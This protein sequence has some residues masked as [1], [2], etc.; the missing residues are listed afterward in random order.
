[1]DI[2][3]RQAGPKDAARIS[4]IYLQSRKLYLPYAPLA[5]SDDAVRA[6]IRETLIPSEPVFVAETEN[7]ILG[8]ISLS[9]EDSVR[10]IDNLYLSPDSTGLGIGKLL[11]NFAL[12]KLEPPVRLYA[13]QEN[14]GARKF[15][16]AHGFKEIEFSDGSNNEE[17]TPDVLMEWEA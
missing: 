3:I 11:L 12:D 15:Y 6:W 7:K 17:N 13:F 9:A 1:M 16:K 4:E 14:S 5:H 8:M 2:T 10:W